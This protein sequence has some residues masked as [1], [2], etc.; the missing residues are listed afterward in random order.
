MLRESA[1]VVILGLAVGI[2]AAL[3]LSRFVRQFLFGLPAND[4]ATMIGAAATL[5]LVA[6]LAAL[7]PARRA[8]RLA[9]AR[10]AQ[11]RIRR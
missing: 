4:P 5:L 3:S 11:W 6:L 9:G 2:A 8:S 1:L 10:R 7:L